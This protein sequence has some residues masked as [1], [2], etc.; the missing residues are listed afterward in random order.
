MGNEWSKQG[1]GN[2]TIPLILLSLWLVVGWI[3][4]IAIG[5]SAYLIILI[6]LLI[7]SFLSSQNNG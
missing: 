2:E 4:I 5:V 3:S 1:C 7:W 6:L